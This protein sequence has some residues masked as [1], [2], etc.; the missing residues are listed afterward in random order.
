MTAMNAELQR[1]VRDAHGAPVQLIDPQTNESYVLMK[2]ETYK[3]LSA[4][5]DGDGFS[6][7]EKLALLA[8]AGKRA[9][10][11]SPEMDEYDE[12][13]GNRP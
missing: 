4:V 10:W 2:E 9:G 5:F 12:H 7:E 11:D 3:R 13:Y 8:E 1:V 6:R